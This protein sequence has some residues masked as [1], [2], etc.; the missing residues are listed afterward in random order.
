MRYLLNQI[1]NKD[2]TLSNFIGALKSGRAYSFNGTTMIEPLNHFVGD[3]SG[4]THDLF[5]LIASAPRELAEQAAELL[6]SDDFLGSFDRV[7]DNQHL[8]KLAREMGMYL[9]QYT[10]SIASQEPW[11]E[12]YMNPIPVLRIWRTKDDEVVGEPEERNVTSD[13][14][15]SRLASMVIA[16]GGD[17]RTNVMISVSDGRYRPDGENAPVREDFL[18]D[19]PGMFAKGFDSTNLKGRR[20]STA[21]VCGLLNKM[22][23]EALPLLCSIEAMAL[24]LSRRGALVDDDLIFERSGYE[25][26]RKTLNPEDSPNALIAIGEWA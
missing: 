12:I 16:E 8:A 6:K 18:V 24:E 23:M 20:A 21:H 22:V 3:P 26:P 9:D 13:Q 19:I 2:A 5:K 10:K 25:P 4:Y 1:F 15:R 7:A 14:L 17:G 11:K